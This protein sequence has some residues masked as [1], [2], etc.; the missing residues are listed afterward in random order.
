VHNF[1][2]LIQNGTHLTLKSLSETHRVII[3]HLQTSGATSLVKGLQMI[4]LQKVVMIT[5]MFS[6]FDAEL[7][8]ELSCKNGL[9]EASRILKEK[10][11]IKLLERFNNFKLAIN[12]LKHGKGRSYD[13]LVVNS[14]NISFR[15]KL[16]HEDFFEEG[17]VSE[18]STLIQVDDNLVIECAD[19]IS[20]VSSFLSKTL[21]K[22]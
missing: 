22:Y 21:N 4:Q 8:R 13:D 18:V 3:E 1:S 19:L 5:G 20:E 15:L 7:Q 16:P 12:V 11:E 9:S 10:N 14:K 2:E 6:I 17:D